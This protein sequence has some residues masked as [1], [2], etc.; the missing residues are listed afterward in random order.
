MRRKAEKYAVVVHGEKAVLRL[1]PQTTSLYFLV[2]FR[3]SWKYGSKVFLNK[4][5]YE[6]WYWLNVA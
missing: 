1:R 3:H 5:A 6:D 2:S 4:T